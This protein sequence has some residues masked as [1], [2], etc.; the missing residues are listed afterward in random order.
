MWDKLGLAVGVF[1]TGLGVFLLYGAISKSDWDES[2]SII[3]G[4]AFFRSD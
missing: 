1:F 2:T 4:A 3:S